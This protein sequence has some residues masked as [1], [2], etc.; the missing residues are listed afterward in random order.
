MLQGGTSLTTN[1]RMELRA[2]LAAFQ[3]LTRPCAVEIHTDSEYLKK[4]VTEW[5]AGWLRNGWRTS[6]KQP[7]KNR[8][9]WQALNA[10]MKPHRITW[11]WVKGHAGDEF[12]ERADQLAVAT[13]NTI[14]VKGQPDLEDAAATYR[15][16]NDERT[17]LRQR[18]KAIIWP[19]IIS[20]G[21]D[22]V[23]MDDYSE[24]TGEV[25]DL[26]P[27]RRL[28]LADL[29]GPAS[30]L[31]T[32]LILTWRDKL[33]FGLEP[34]AIPLGAQGRNML[35]RSQASVATSTQASGGRRRWC[36]RRWRRRAV[37]C[38]WGTAP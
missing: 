5:M 14:G 29:G 36:V 23:L 2:A 10:A 12:N 9:L 32:G 31:S 18:M 17:T 33:V 3:A 26:V 16:D 38:R 20:P 15:N 13:L 24:L 8:D 35:P 21:T 7:V 28:D 22:K 27:G 1:N 19:F 11:H 30:E 37:R 4:G 6:S 34:R 25:P